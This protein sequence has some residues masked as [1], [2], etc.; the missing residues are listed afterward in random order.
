MKSSQLGI[1]LE[2]TGLPIRP[3]LASIAPLGRYGIRTV[4]IDAVGELNPDQL[5]GT[6]RREL[7]TVLKSYNLECAALHCP[8]RRMLD[9]PEQLQARLD[10]LQKVLQ[11]AV[12]LG[13][14]LVVMPLAKIPKDP[15]T[16]PA[17][18]LRESL[19]FLGKNADRL[20]VR[21]A[22]EPGLDPGDFV[23]DYLKGYDLE[24]LGICYDPAN[25]FLNGFDP[26]SS[27]TA[28]APKLVYVQARDAR[29]AGVAA[30]G[31][32]V[33]VGAGLIDWFVYFAT[34]SANEYRGP[35]V[36][37]REEGPSRFQDASTGARFLTRFLSPL[38]S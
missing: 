33:A 2:T 35:V 7:K 29:P 18:T 10:H 15:T 12:D 14:R 13:P 23:R 22:L 21:L 38:E 6:G 1:V 34:L 27:L 20:G 4:Q 8:L 9:N 28:L 3:A 31:K 16:V 11:L 17:Q 32:E 37:D 30:N 26:V 5:T 19:E 36:V 25:F 24:S